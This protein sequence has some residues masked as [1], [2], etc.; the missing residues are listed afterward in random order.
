MNI[1]KLIFLLILLLTFISCRKPKETT[2]EHYKGKGIVVIQKPYR[3]LFQSPD[4][5]NYHVVCKTKDSTFT[6]ILHDFDSK[7]L[8]VGDTIK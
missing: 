3:V 2:I 7:D 6:I 4:V 5:Y 8:K 1:K